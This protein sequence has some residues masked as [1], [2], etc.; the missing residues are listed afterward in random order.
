M[1]TAS[2]GSDPWLLSLD[3]DE[4]RTRLQQRSWGASRGPAVFRVPSH[5]RKLQP[6]CYEVDI[7]PLGLY[8][9]DFRNQTPIDQFKLELLSVFLNYLE[10]DQQVWKTFCAE[11][12]TPPASGSVADLEHF[13][14]NDAG[15]S[16]MTLDLA[17]SALIIDAF[18]V[19]AYFI[20]ICERYS[21]GFSAPPLLVRQTMEIFT[22]AYGVGVENALDK[23]IFWLCENQIP[24]FLCLH[25][26]ISPAGAPPTTIDAESSN[27]TE[28]ML[29]ALPSASELH[30]SGIRF[31]GTDGGDIRL[32]K[33]FHRLTAILYIPRMK[34]QDSSEKLLRNM[35]VYELITGQTETRGFTHYVNFMDE[36]INEEEDVRLLMQGKPPVIAGNFMGDNKIGFF[37]RFVKAPWLFVSL[38][39]ATILLVLTLL[40]TIYTMWGFY[41]QY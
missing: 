21:R 12:A 35:C 18:V 11:I 8:N 29:P 28:P 19:V 38:V 26:A 33:S 13:Y 32:V 30:K 17:Q 9:R 41:N 1:A 40:Q 3:I 5:I 15:Q 39:A 22:R 23:D 10:V 14:A 36:L 24:L 37:D 4:L 2:T 31:R 7:L 27:R 6:Q 34:I 25:K 16:F 20:R